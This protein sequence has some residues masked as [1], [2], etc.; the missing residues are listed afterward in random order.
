[1]KIAHVTDFYL[2]RLGGIEMQVAELTGR[3]RAAGHEVHVITSSPAA[4]DGPGDGS[5][6]GAGQY[7]AGVPYGPDQVIR[8]TEDLR[9]QDAIHPAAWVRGCREV[10]EGGY[11]L[12]HAHLGV[13]TPL[14]FFVALDAAKHGIPTVVT[15]HSL[16]AWIIPL[17]RLFDAVIG[18]SRQPIVWTA[19][20]DAAARH[21]RR[22]LPDGAVVHVIP[23]GIDPERWRR[24][25]PHTEIDGEITVAAVMRLSARKRPLPLLR[26]VR[27]AQH[28]LAEDGIRLRL[29]IAGNGPRLKAMQ[30]F[31]ERNDMTDSVTLHGRL[32]SAQVRDL[33]QRSD[34]FIA[35]A[36]LESFGLAALEAR[37]AG[38]P[39]IAKAAGGLPEFIRHER[40]GLICETD[41]DMTAALVRL[42]RD[43]GLLRSIQDY[44]AHQYCAVIWPYTLTLLGHVYEEACGSDVT[45]L[46]PVDLSP[47]LQDAVAS[48]ERA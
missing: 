7:L 17:F 12:V 34:A 1:M 48:H 18:W 11:D 28:Q 39:I 4:K 45:L 30:R 14:G 24:T 15:V 46:P 23:N 26:M 2:P 37:C 29:R 43:R 20:S 3:E 31:L 42:G 8:V 32:T 5:S 33:H 41:G 25:R 16:W 9:V 44:N 10:R 13:G 35:P 38:L 40:E 6:G 19:V 21:V 47:L 27:D 22:V 36:D